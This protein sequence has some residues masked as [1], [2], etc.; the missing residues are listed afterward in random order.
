M[1]PFFAALSKALQAPKE[2][3]PMISE[4][5]YPPGVTE[6][7]LMLDFDLKQACSSRAVTKNFI[8]KILIEIMNEI[9]R[10]FNICIESNGDYVDTDANDGLTFNVAV[11]RK[12][13]PIPD[14]GAYKDGFHLLFPDFRM[15]RAQKAFLIQRLQHSA[16]FQALWDEIPMWWPGCL[17]V[18]DTTAA[19][20]YSDDHRLL[21]SQ[22][23]EKTLDENSA[24]VPVFF[25]GS[26]SK[27]KSP[28][29]SLDSVYIIQVTSDGEMDVDLTDSAAFAN[30]PRSLSL[31]YARR[32]TI[33]VD[34][35]PHWISAIAAMEGTSSNSEALTELKEKIDS[36]TQTNPDA[37]ALFKLIGILPL[38]MSENYMPWDKVVKALASA[39]GDNYMCLA[40]WFSRKVPTAFDQAKWPKQWKE[41]LDQHSKISTGYIWASA[42]KA[43]PAE[44]EKIK[45]TT[46]NS[47]LFAVMREN[48]YDLNHKDAASIFEIVY[49]GHI[50]Y[51]DSD[52]EP[53]MYMLAVP[54]SQIDTTKAGVWKWVPIPKSKLETALRRPFR[55]A[56]ENALCKALNVQTAA[57]QATTNTEKKKAISAVIRNIRKSKRNLGMRGFIPSALSVLSGEIWKSKFA[58]S[59]NSYEHVI[60]VR[61]GILRLG[62]KAILI[63]AVSPFRISYSTNA[64]YIP[65]DPEDEMC[66]EMLKTYR[67]LFLNTHTDVFNVLMHSFAQALGNGRKP[68]VFV[69]CRGV[70]TGNGKS[71]I[72]DMVASVL[73]ND[74]ARTIPAGMFETGGTS[75]AE[76]ASPALLSLASANLATYHENTV[77]NLLASQPVKTFTG[78]DQQTGRALFSNDQQTFTMHALL[79]FLSNG[80]L[81]FDNFTGIARRYYGIDFLKK[82]LS[83]N[84]ID[85]DVEL[86]EYEGIADPDIV[87]KWPKDPARIARMLG[88]IVAFSENLYRF[89]DNNFTK[90]SS[91][92]CQAQRDEYI[93]SQDHT[94]KFL[95]NCV[96]RVF[97]F[98]TPVTPFSQDEQIEMKDCVDFTENLQITQISM[99]TLKELEARMKKI[100][101]IYAN[102]ANSIRQGAISAH[103]DPDDDSNISVEDLY[104]VYKEWCQINGYNE[105]KAVEGVFKKNVLNNILMKKYIVVGGPD[106]DY[107]VGHKAD[108]RRTYNKGPEVPL[109]Y[110][111]HINVDPSQ[112]MRMTPDEYVDEFNRRWRANKRLPTGLID[113]TFENAPTY[114]G[115]ME[116]HP[117]DGIDDSS[118]C[119]NEAT[120]T[121]T[122]D[123]V[124][125]SMARRRDPPV[126]RRRGEGIPI[127]SSQHM[128]GARIVDGEVDEDS[129][130]QIEFSDGEDEVIYDN[131]DSVST[132]GSCIDPGNPALRGGELSDYDDGSNDDSDSGESGNDG[133]STVSEVYSG[134]SRLTVQSSAER[135]MQ[136]QKRRTPYR[137]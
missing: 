9:L 95:L 100:G 39:G 101:V 68:Q 54:G 134:V 136:E 114:T 43:N 16:V 132:F 115:V 51:S 3:L 48:G 17:N 50:N 128:F 135:A 123:I 126:D 13:R 69:H 42:M 112:F 124:S 77:G 36:L 102:R 93:T 110:A 96:F 31:N 53:N 37:D 7:G 5:Q 18:T 1:S 66:R 15:T 87:Q 41:R 57:L 61:N 98:T 10:T 33:P 117:E 111:K 107:I 104:K 106:G 24:H 73:G 55:Q 6:S 45:K 27:P 84:E 130:S 58:Q 105:I 12:P 63:E 131:D 28:P 23:V 52:G 89:Y 127:S 49:S 67:N 38:S 88:I 103:E 64:A 109:K 71:S 113:D 120:E 79:M 11:T 80:D 92:H 19:G 108:S 78:G 30:D 56:V 82:F 44:F 85:T 34:T 74:Y 90:V 99:T 47:K 25:V 26:P 20:S 121:M 81:K 75:G 35:K 137:R 22:Q 122:R 32:G 62:P 70:S 116:P 59:L 83:P 94:N 72:G 97:D 119:Y 21:R 40:E 60:G 133:G 14:G 76:S 86:T 46:V 29:Y 91:P 8:R 65:Y 125:S 118:C 4:M 129:K 2:K